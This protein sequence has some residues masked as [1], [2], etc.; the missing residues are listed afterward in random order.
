MAIC[1]PL[2]PPPSPNHPSSEKKLWEKNKFNKNIQLLYLLAKDWPQ[3]GKSY[4]HA[5]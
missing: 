4:T 5:N 3:L 2:P 1:Q